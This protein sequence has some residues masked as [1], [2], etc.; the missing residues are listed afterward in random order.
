MIAA[1]TKS[2]QL[3]FSGWLTD[4]MTAPTP[5]SSLLHSASMVTA[6]IFLLLRFRSLFFHSIG[7]ISTALTTLL[8]IVAIIK[9][10]LKKIIAFSTISQLGMMCLSCGL[11]NYSGAIF[12]IFTH[13]FFKA[14]LFLTAATVIHS[15]NEQSITKLGGLTR[16]LPLLTILLFLSSMSLIGVPFYAGFY[17]KDFI[18]EFNA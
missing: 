18:L 13:A 5:T 7:A 17:S 12:Q 15:V 16:S 3:P 2:A 6:G 9:S 11:S 8:G 10:D 14:L 4:C 1:F